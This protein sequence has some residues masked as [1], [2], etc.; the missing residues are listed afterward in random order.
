MTEHDGAGC[1]LRDQAFL[2]ALVERVAARVADRV[3]E[4]LGAPA[5]QPPPEQAMEMG[6]QLLGD[7]TNLRHLVRTVMQALTTPLSPVAEQDMAASAPLP[8]HRER[9]DDE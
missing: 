5:A 6:A 9:L 3:C 2:D 4:R 1:P 7:P 8:L